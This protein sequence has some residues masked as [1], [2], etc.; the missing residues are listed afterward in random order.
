MR[1]AGVSVLTFGFRVCT[2]D[3]LGFSDVCYCLGFRAKGGA[4]GGEALKS[5]KPT[6]ELEHDRAIFCITIFSKMFGFFFIFFFFFFFFSVCLLASCCLLRK[7]SMRKTNENSMGHN[8]A[9]FSDQG[10]RQ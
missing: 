6:P 1:G 5:P 8:K 3:F 9:L 4:A 10:G 7:L 2:R